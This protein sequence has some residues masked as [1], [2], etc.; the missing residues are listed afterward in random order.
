MSYFISQ[1]LIVYNIVR[2]LGEKKAIENSKTLM[3]IKLEGRQT[4]FWNYALSY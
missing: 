1:K 3:T 4:Q 2:N